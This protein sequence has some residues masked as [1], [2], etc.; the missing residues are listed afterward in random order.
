MRT[1]HA[2][3]KSMKKI[4][5]KRTLNKTKQSKGMLVISDWKARNA[6]ED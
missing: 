5:L 6:S 2:E 3:N 4:D 1:Q